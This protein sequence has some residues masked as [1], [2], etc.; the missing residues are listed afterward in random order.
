MRVKEMFVA[1]AGIVV[2]LLIA[3]LY[4][5]FFP[6]PPPPPPALLCPAGVI[7]VDVNVIQVGDQSVIQPIGNIVVNG[8]K[9]IIWNVQTSGYTFPALAAPT[10][11]ATGIDFTNTGTKPPAPP[12]EVTCHQNSPTQI[13]CHD[14]H[15]H[16]GMWGYT[17][18]LSGTPSVM[19]LD[20]FIVNR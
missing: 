14:D 20:P 18:T 9:D 10:G 17:V 5:I 13:R 12:G 19:A 8:K 7:C 3:F 1:I 16:L 11:P 2:G 15:G 4:P 6:P